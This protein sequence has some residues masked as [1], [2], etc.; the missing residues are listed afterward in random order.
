MCGKQTNKQI[1][2]GLTFFINKVILFTTVIVLD[3]IR[4]FIESTCT[5]QNVFINEVDC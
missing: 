5:K 2:K 1:N 3:H 4:K